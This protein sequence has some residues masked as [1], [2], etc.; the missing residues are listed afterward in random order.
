MLRYVW[1]SG[2][3]IRF[4]LEAGHAVSER[5]HQWKSVL[6]IKRLTTKQTNTFKHRSTTGPWSL[7]SWLDQSG[8][9]FNFVWF[10]IPNPPCG[11]FIFW[12]FPRKSS[13]SKEQKNMKKCMI[14]SIQVWAFPSLHRLTWKLGNQFT[15]K[16]QHGI[17]W[18][19]LGF[20][21]LGKCA[22]K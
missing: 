21:L 7:R 8:A 13:M 19:F 4:D 16:I 18:L 2:Y 6:G 11:S 17:C 3:R 15:F 12:A 9:M 14:G 20:R 5:Y 1:P 22:G 10:P